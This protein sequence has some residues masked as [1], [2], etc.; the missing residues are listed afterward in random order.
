MANRDFTKAQFD[1]ALRRNGFKHEFMGWYVD[2]TGQSGG[3]RFGAV[4]NTK[5]FRINRRATLARLI[6]D[7]ASHI[8][9][10]GRQ[11]P[12]RSEFVAA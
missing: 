11:K 6:R 12:A 3:V 9:E 4:F 10:Q 5:P 2:T 8:A 1:A 7:R